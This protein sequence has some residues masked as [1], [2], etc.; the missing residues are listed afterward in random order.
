[1]CI[2]DA[3]VQRHIY[4]LRWRMPR[5][6]NA[7]HYY[8]QLSY[9]NIRQFSINTV[10]PPIPFAHMYKYIRIYWIGAYTLYEQLRSIN[11]MIQT[12]M[13]FEAALLNKIKSRRGFS[14]MQIAADGDSDGEQPPIWMGICPFQIGVIVHFPFSH[15]YCRCTIHI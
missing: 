4:R 8:I 1:M 12:G 10:N 2:L 9:G 3:C 15:S 13:S 11:G 6:K 14:L 7:T 5:I